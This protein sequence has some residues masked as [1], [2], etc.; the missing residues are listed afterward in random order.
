VTNA[1]EF[2]DLIIIIMV[3]IIMLCNTA[4][5]TAEREKWLMGSGCDMDGRSSEWRGSY[6]VCEV[7]HQ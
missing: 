1:T 4:M 3:Y 2:I 7:P 5:L 6:C